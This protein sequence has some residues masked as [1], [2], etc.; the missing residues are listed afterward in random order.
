MP[1]P[2]HSPKWWPTPSF[3]NS[4]L[5]ASTHLAKPKLSFSGVIQRVRLPA[6]TTP[7]SSI[8]IDA[9][10]PSIFSVMTH[11]RL[12]RA[13]F[14]KALNSII[15]SPPKEVHEPPPAKSQPTP[16]YRHDSCRQFAERGR[17]HALS[18]EFRIAGWRRTPLGCV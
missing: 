3:I 1:L 14:G 12:S 2:H 6:I 16:A 13:I 8:R 15:S 5:F 4:D 9:L 10:V 7:S 18:L 17:L 11:S